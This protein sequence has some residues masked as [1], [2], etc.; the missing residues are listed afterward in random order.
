MDREG[1]PLQ[2]LKGRCA[3]GL[4]NNGLSPPSEKGSMF[5]FK[6]LKPAACS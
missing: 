1:R 3:I 4:P 5:A 2:F 6:F